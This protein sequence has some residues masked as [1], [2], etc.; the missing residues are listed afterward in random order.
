MSQSPQKPIDTT[1]TFPKEHDVRFYKS[2][3]KSFETKGNG[4]S[5][6]MILNMPIWGG[7]LASDATLG[8]ERTMCLDNLVC[9]DAGYSLERI[10]VLSEARVKETTFCQ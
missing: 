6:N 3:T 5:L 9:W 2:S 7:L 10:N 4:T 1:H 8:G